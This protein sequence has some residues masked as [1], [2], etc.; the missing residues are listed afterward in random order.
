MRIGRFL[1]RLPATAFL[2]AIAI[3][4]AVFFISRVANATSLHA[5]RQATDIIAPVSTTTTLT[6]SP[7]SSALKGQEVALIATVTPPAALGTVQFKDGDKILGDNKMVPVN[8]GIAKGTITQLDVGLHQLQ[9]VFTPT[10]KDAYI[11]SKSEPKPFTVTAPPA[12][13][14]NTVLTTRTVQGNSV[15]LI[16]TVTPPEATGTV[17]F[18]DDA[19]NLG[20]PVP[21][22]N[23]TASETRLISRAGQ[24]Q[25]TAEFTP[26][27]TARFL[28]SKSDAALLNVI[29]SP[30]TVTSEAQASGQ[31]L[32]GSAGRDDRGGAVVNL[33][34]G[35]LTDG[36]GVT[37]LD[38]GN[39]S[40]NGGLTLLDLGGHND[41]GGVT[42]LD[43][44]DLTVLRDRGSGG[45]LSSLLHALL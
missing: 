12:T 37:L 9:A 35:G 28:P 16:V 34:L 4:G 6:T 39:G 24:H 44:G 15:T 20:D 27:D 19:M 2:A 43:G 10:D 21:I 26:D 25:L 5:D 33:D 36:H 22:A 13:K 14:T 40:D 11:P 30:Q 29:Q 3:T 42:L 41:R 8:A 18:K 7:P 31:S 1:R 32:D 45:L 23:G 17:Q 38:G